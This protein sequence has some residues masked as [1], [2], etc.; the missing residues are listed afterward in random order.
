[1]RSPL[2]A[3][4]GETIQRRRQAL[5]HGVST[6]CFLAS[7]CYLERVGAWLSLVERSVRDREVGGSNPLAPT[8]SF[9]HLTK[10]PHTTVNFRVFFCKKAE[11]WN[12][13]TLALSYHFAVTGAFSAR[14]QRRCKESNCGKMG[15]HH[16]S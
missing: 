7:L 3:S 2:A 13:S 5:G 4:Y 12:D 15:S 6:C 14:L 11:G 8:I 9:K 10:T 1:M 16:Y